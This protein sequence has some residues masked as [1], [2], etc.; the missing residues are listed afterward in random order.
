M[1]KEPLGL[2]LLRF[3]MGGM[4]FIFLLMLYW[5]S[6]LAES[7]LK[8]I[9]SDVSQIKSD[10]ADLHTTLGQLK[11]GAVQFKNSPSF[12]DDL[13][14]ETHMDE[15]LPNLL[16]EDPFFQTT[17]PQI[18]G[19]LFK[20]KG[21]FHRAELGKPENL[22]PFSHWRVVS[23]LR[24]LCVPSVARLQF[25]K[26]ETL[27]PDLAIRMEKRKD[28]ETGLTEFWVFLRKDL[29][30]QPLH[31][32]L[33]SEEIRLAP[34]FMQKHPVTAHDFKFYYDAMMNP[35]NQEAGAVSGRTYYSDVDSVRVIDDLTFVVRWKG[36]PIKEA[37]GKITYKPKYVSAQ[38][39][40]GLN[41][42]PR[43]VYQYFPD[44]KKIIEDDTDP[45][46][47]R[48]NPVWGQNFSHHWAKNIIVGCGPWIFEQMTDRLVKFKR[49]PNYFSPYDALAEGIEIQFKDTSD[50]MWQ[51]FKVNQLD[52][53][54]IRPEQLSELDVFINSPQYKAQIKETSSNEINRLD[55]LSRAY[56]YVG[57]NQAKPYFKSKK[58]RQALTMAIDRKRI[59]SQILNNMGVEITGTFYINSPAYDPSIKP[60]PFDLRKAKQLLEEDGWYDSDGDGTIDKNIDG[61]I[62]PFRF[63]LMY[64]V[65]GHTGKAIAEFISTGLK[66]IG[67]DCRLQGVDIAD[68]SAA[69]ENKSFDAIM[70]AWSLGTPPDDPKQLWYSKDSGEKGSSNA[71]GFSN[72]EADSIIEKL[73]YESD[74]QKRTQLYHQFDAILHEEAPYTFLFTPKVAMLYRNYLQNVF[75]PADRQDLIPGANVGEPD[76]AI[77]WLKRDSE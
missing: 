6:N 3:F 77:F 44:G 37:D 48:K 64:Y 30:W 34:H 10:L 58:V 28:K 38:L 76:S 1:N 45:E 14:V 20:Y 71:I 65:K 69:F 18:L 12:Q 52:Y 11:N 31:A 57:W 25:G 56:S 7:D 36:E 4:L 32:N 26:Y 41:P 60:W 72:P 8:A 35:Y 54:E 70:M 23:S 27:A 46:T 19:N 59:I 66:E 40:S 63:N 47:Y 74:P 51:L 43:F 61:K 29:Y 21:V 55:F 68:L 49:N 5:S 2:Y 16:K 75:I 24:A 33:F 50:A 67:I 62:V 13:S 73:I 39:T 53:Y 22:H 17:L 9:R 42:L 15:S